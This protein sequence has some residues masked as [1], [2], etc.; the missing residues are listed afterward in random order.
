MLKSRL[1]PRPPVL[2]DPRLLKTGSKAIILICLGLCASTAGFSSTIYFPGLPYITADLHAPA[3][4]TTLTAALFVLAMGIAPVFWASLSDFYR[5]R[6][7]LLMAS[8]LIFAAASLGSAFIN[9][10]W[11]LVVLRCVQSL[12]A[13]CGQSVGAGIIAVSDC[14]AIEQRGAAFGKFFFGVFFGPL[15]GPI[16]GGFLIMSALSWRATFWF[17]FAFALFI[18]TCLFLFFP[19]TYRDN[20]KYDMVL[21]TSTSSISDTLDE[22]PQIDENGKDGTVTQNEEKTFVAPVRKPVNPFGAFILLKHPFILLS[23]VISGIAFGCMF[24]VETII[25]DLYESHY[26]FN[27]WQTGLS[28][29]GAGVGNLFGSFVGGMLSDRLLMRSRRLRGGRAVVEDRLTANLWPCCFI[30]IPFGILLFGWSIERG[31]TVWAP[32]VAFGIQTFGM[33]QVMTSTSA[34]LVDAIPG[35]GASA[36]AAANLVRMI[37]ACALTL[38]A[39]PMVAAIGPGYT[40]VFLAALS[41]IACILLVILK[42]KGEALRIKSGY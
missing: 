40:C 25:P 28:Y 37:L 5:V 29:L 8:M 21:P 39:N 17:C 23:A 38:A 16:I 36:T 2:S 19:E 4:A 24:A 10:I 35:Q 13:S 30:V 7:I 22:Q 42:L 1:L 41:V 15:L 26:G 12:G 6:R 20:Q 34:Y 11:G 31:L 27:S 18:F 3:I 32:I 33:N 14:Y 9:N